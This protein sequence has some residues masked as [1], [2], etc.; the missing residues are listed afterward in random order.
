MP[1]EI[2]TSEELEIFRIRLPED[3]KKVLEPTNTPKKVW[4]K[5]KQLRSLLNISPNTLEAP[6]A[7]FNQ[8]KLAAV[9]NCCK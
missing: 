6:C 2:I 4:L 7:N 3:L 5:S 9:L 1:V 8:Q